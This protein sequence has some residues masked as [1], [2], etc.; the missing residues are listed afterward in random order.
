M[1]NVSEH[2]PCW[3]ALGDLAV[4]ILRQ[5]SYSLG[6]SQKTENLLTRRLG[7]VIIYQG[8]G[9]FGREVVIALRG[10]NTRGSQ[11]R[12]PSVRS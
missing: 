11:G 7:C 2:I 3:A 5:R 9:L 10:G 1:T 12:C 4:W 8:R 6:V